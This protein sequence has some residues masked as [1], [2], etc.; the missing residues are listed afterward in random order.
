MAGK[1]QHHVWR[2]LQRGFGE[3][4]GKDHHIW[5]Y[6]K[7]AKPSRKGT[8]NFGV[9][10]FFYGPEGS[11]TDKSITNFE[12]SVQS[13]IQDARK[14]DD[15][16]ELSASFVA[17][18][19]AHLEVRSNFLRSELS[20]LT[21]RMQAALADH[22]SSTAKVKTM[23]KDY[24]KNNPKELDK[25]LAK[26]FVPGNQREAISKLL[27]TYIDNLPTGMAENVFD[28]MVAQFFQLANLAPDGIKEAHNKALLEIKPESPRIKAWSDFDYTVYRPKVGQLILPDT[29]CTF[30][31]LKKVTPFSQ[32]KDDTHTVIIPISSEVAIMGRKGKEGPME[33]KTIN[34]LLAGSAYDAFIARTDDPVLASLAGRIGKHA[35]MM[36]DKEVRELF[37]F[38]RLLST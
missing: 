31:G 13:S 21:E 1:E 19:I 24:L 29:C 35:K 25:L 12:N 32:P 17:P 8:R 7:G 4:R 30:V 22:L 9:D 15:G 34:R 37:A 2:M 6:R 27:D 10:R 14:L 18:L 26:N 20:N 5:V 16:A 28:G 23:M 11:E 38:E 3:K 36:S 33:L